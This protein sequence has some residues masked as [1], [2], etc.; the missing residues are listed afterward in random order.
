[1]A[2]TWLTY[3]LFPQK[4]E[5]VQ[6]KRECMERSL[7]DM[8]NDMQEGKLKQVKEKLRADLIKNYGCMPEIVAPVEA[9][10]D[11]VAAMEGGAEVEQF[12]KKILEW[13]RFYTGKELDRM[14]NNKIGFVTGEQFVEKL[15]ALKL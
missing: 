11:Y 5:S 13:D 9:V 1:M 7:R 12:I 4:E 15:K 6:Q 10:I 2:P 14:L 8:F 3:Q